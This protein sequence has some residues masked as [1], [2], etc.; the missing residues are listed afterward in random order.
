MAKKNLKAALQSTQSRLKAKEKVAQA[1]QV[2]ELKSRKPGPQ[3]SRTSGN[4]KPT[5]NI[6][7][8]GKQ[9]MT[10]GPPRK[11]LIPFKLSDKILLI[12]EGNFSFARSL[13]QNPPAELRS[14]PPGSITATAYDTEKECYEKYP[15]AQE[16]VSLLKEKGVEVLFGV[17]GTRL[18]KHTALKGKKW[19]RIV[20][21]FPHAGE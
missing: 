18:E 10:P 14:L 2:A 3:S 11:P 1:A 13:V 15:E 12:G 9:K 17:D 21:N 19:D 20:W 16:I 6:K 5:A 8:K 4:G 7:G